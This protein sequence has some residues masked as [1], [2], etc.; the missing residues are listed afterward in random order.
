ML[1]N[2]GWG[3]TWSGSWRSH[4]HRLLLSWKVLVTTLMTDIDRK[5]HADKEPRTLRKESMAWL[6]HLGYFNMH[7]TQLIHFPL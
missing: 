7:S 2:Q 1:I 6:S 3:N 5:F 4:S